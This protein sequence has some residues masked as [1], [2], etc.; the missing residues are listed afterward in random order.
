M[1]DPE[2]PWNGHKMALCMTTDDGNDD[3]MDWV[4]VWQAAGVRFSLMVN[5]N[6][7]GL[8]GKLT[9]A[10]LRQI[11]ADGFEIGNHGLDHIILPSLS[12]VDLAA[13]VDKAPLE[14]LIGDGYKVDTF[15]YPVHLHDERVMKAVKDAGYMGARGGYVGGV[16]NLGAYTG[17]LRHLR[18]ANIYNRFEMD[19]NV[20][21]GQLCGANADDEPTTR[22]KVQTMLANAKAYQRQFFIIIGSAHFTSTC[23]A[24][25][26][27]WI[28][29]EVMSDSEVWVT[30]FR[31]A[32]RYLKF[33]EDE[34]G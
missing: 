8:T 7:I 5:A 30:T 17:M 26:M 19:L 34:D 14:A 28:V 27:G 9:L 4:P 32:V 31:E 25:H 13:Q 2:R 24:T 20:T 18:P 12:D 15:C 16:E 23:D 11:A 21:I 3:N 10:Q 29:D 6:T 1:N 22:G 33:W